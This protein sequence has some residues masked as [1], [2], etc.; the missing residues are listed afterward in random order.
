MIIKNKYGSLFRLLVTLSAVLLLSGCSGN[1]SEGNSTQQ[2]TP[3]NEASATPALFTVA[4]ADLGKICSTVHCPE[5]S[6]VETVDLKGKNYYSSENA[7]VTQYVNFAKQSKDKQQ[8][9]KYRA[10]AVVQNLKT[11]LNLSYLL[12]GG[13]AYTVVNNPDTPGDRIPLMQV[14]DL[15]N[16]LTVWVPRAA[17]KVVK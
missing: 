10:E 16:D 14:H 6:Q 11:G 9:E 13:V 8:I 15:T 17:V 4:P 3:A 12:K 1:E 7:A 5:G 2:I